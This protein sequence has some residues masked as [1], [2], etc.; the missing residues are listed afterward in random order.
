MKAGRA[1]ILA[2]ALSAS[3]PLHADPDTPTPVAA[4]STGPAAIIT[5]G[6]PQRES[7][8][9][10]T[11]PG[12]APLLSPAARNQLPCTLAT[13]RPSPWGLCP[14]FPTS[15][16]LPL[17]PGSPTAG[18]QQAFIVG[19]KIE[20]IQQGLSQI[21]GGVQLDQGDHRVTGENMLYDSDTGVVTIKQDVNYYT[22][23]LMLSSQSGRYD[24]N[25]NVG[26]FDGADFL[27]PSRHGHGTARLV[28]SLDA[29]RSQLFD[30]HY[31]T[32]PPDRVDWKLNAPDLLLDTATN[33]GEAHDV[34]IDFMG[35]PVLWLPYINFPLNDERKSG[36][37]SGA[38][39]YDGLDGLEVEAPY[40]LN[41]AP[42]YD[43]TLYPRIITKRG[44]QLGNAFRLLTPATYSYLYASYL[45][46]DML[47]DRAR[48]Q[49]IAEEEIKLAPQLKMSGEYN[50]ISD[51]NFFRDLSSDLAI[52]SSTYLNR[53]LNL[54]YDPS[55]DLSAKATAQD[56]QVID[57]DIA[58]TNYPFREMPDLTATWGNFSAVSG[59][60]YQLGGEL[61]RFQRAGRLGGWRLDAKPSISLP[62]TGAA[63]FFTPTLAWRYQR[64][65]LGEQRLSLPAGSSALIANPLLDSSSHPSLSVPLFSISTGLYFDRD[66]GDYLQ[67]LEP[68]LFY[69]RVP[70]RDQSQLPDFDTNQIPFSFLQL[71]S[72][73]N[74]YGGDRQSDANQLSYALTS[75]ILDPVTGAEVL[76]GD[77]GQIRYFSDRRVQLGT[78]CTAPGVPTG[79]APAQTNLFSDVAGEV[80][81]DLNDV[82]T[83][84]YQQ[85]WSPVTRRTDMASVLFQ[86]HP[87]YRQVLN[88]GFQY[89]APNYNGIALKQTDLSFSSPLSGSWSAVGRWNY[90]VVNHITL[91]DFV[92]VEYDSCCWNFQILHRHV[93]IAQNTYDNVFFLQLSLKGLVT[94]GRHLDDLVENGILGYSDNAYTDSQQALPP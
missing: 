55:L 33:T 75:R 42:N 86:Y 13:T 19:D 79:C 32:C 69:L 29:D 73:N 45:P 57:P 9:E 72:D 91:E 28:D 77:I 60:Q 59:A 53:N 4:P 37:L 62:L 74:F 46:H 3:A 84:S 15:P 12:P 11:A 49:L 22:P 88:L 64:Y 36:F 76:R 70:Y 54:S 47:A 27:L 48:G 85:L 81:Y 1:F 92:G 44:L 58:P 2:V 50:W 20:S 31:T 23:Q 43:D 90:D 34:T 7:T 61:V 80:T 6:I 89:Q 26:S 35:I 38:F 94:A 30:V 10:S 17:P 87:G 67:T 66:A 24:T 68:Q 18:R 82:W 83:A 63:G 93:V 78:P 8:C 14:A 21:S 71:F 41:L 52:I 56:Y 39:S 51:D 25:T 65:D 40:Y 16:V 5:K